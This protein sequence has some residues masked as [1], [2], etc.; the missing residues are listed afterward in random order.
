M[1]VEV[2]VTLCTLHHVPVFVPDCQDQMWRG[3]GLSGL[4]CEAARRA[5]L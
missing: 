5:V 3:E 2:P 4:C 1:A